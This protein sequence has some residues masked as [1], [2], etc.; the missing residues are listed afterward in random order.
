MTDEG[1]SVERSNGGLPARHWSSERRSGLGPIVAAFWAEAPLPQKALAVIL[2][3]AVL[4]LLAAFV[5]N[6]R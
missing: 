4:V 2:P 5:L 6:L 1:A 3:L